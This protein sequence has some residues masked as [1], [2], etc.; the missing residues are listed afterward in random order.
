MRG[1]VFDMDGLL[2]DSEPLWRRAEQAAFARVGIE[3]TDEMCRETMGLRSDEVVALWHRR[4][5]WSGVSPDEVLDDLEGRVAALIRSQGRALPGVRRTIDELQS[6]G[7]R[8]ALA[9]SSAPHLIRTVLSTL[10]LV[11]AFDTVCS[12]A[13]E[14]RG[15]PDPAVYNT[16]VRD[17]GLPPSECVA[18][19]DSVAGVQSASAAGLRVIAVPAPEQFDE[20]GFDQA[21]LK[22]G[23]LEEFEIWIL[24]SI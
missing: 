6:A 4:R 15:K 20:P 16:A 14:E 7:M 24:D 23:S 11:D 2:I 13:D 12:A 9:T 17:L 1:A 22:L 18:F 19:E 10:G 5:P 8:M 21:D 3:L